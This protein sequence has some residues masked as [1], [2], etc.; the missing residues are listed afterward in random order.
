ME[1][2]MWA[3]YTTNSEVKANEFIESLW[4]SYIIV[5]IHID[6]T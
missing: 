3:L 6:N 4:A 2:Y 5:M 1:I